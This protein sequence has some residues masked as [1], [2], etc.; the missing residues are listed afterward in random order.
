MRRRLVGNLWNP[1]LL[2]RTGMA[3]FN[4]LQTDLSAPLLLSLGLKA[5]AGGEIDTLRV[6]VDGSYEDTG[7]KILL[8]DP[9]LNRDSLREFLYR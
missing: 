5:L 8:T 1:V 6:P 9:A 3:A 4:A 2:A 7:S